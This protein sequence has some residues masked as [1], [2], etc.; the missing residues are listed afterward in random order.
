MVADERAE[1][2]LPARIGL[3]RA[4]D[5]LGEELLEVVDVVHARAP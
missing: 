4:A 3:E 2:R 1:L 5:V